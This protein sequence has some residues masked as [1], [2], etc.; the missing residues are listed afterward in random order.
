MA[1]RRAKIKEAKLQ[2]KK[3]KIVS[4]AINVATSKISND[5]VLAADGSDFSQ[6]TRDLHQL[7]RTYLN[8]LN[9]LEKTNHNSILK[10]IGWAI[11]LANLHPLLIYNMQGVLTCSGLY[12][13]VEKKFKTVS[14]AAQMNVWH[15]LMNFKLCDHPS[16]AG[17]ASKLHDLA[18]KWKTLKVSMDEDT[19]LGFIFQGSL[20][21]DTA[22]SHDFKQ[23]VEVTVQDHPQNLAPNFDKLVHLV[24]LCQ[25][26]DELA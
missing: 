16:S 6:W 19:F 12:T 7:G 24:K 15:E 5:R 26:Q 25:Q 1:N 17:L 18:S 4:Q 22:M 3:S 11:F 13:F 10:K 23:Q 2:L 14:C 20:N 21:Q 8:A 9:F